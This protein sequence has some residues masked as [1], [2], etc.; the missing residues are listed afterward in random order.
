MLRYCFVLGENERIIS[1]FDADVGFT[2]DLFDPSPLSAVARTSAFNMYIFHN[3]TRITFY[4]RASGYL[5][6]QRQGFFFRIADN[7]G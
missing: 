2:N 3:K 4:L 6:A 5:G 1:C 7:S